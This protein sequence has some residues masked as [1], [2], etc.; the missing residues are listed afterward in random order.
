[1]RKEKDCSDFYNEFEYIHDFGIVFWKSDD[2]L[3]VYDVLDNIVCLYLTDY[4]KFF[5][6]FSIWLNI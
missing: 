4:C 5:V 1:M 2:A 3:L 6:S